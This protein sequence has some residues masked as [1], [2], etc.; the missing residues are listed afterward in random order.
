MSEM[1]VISMNIA[2][3]VTT[4]HRHLSYARPISRSQKIKGTKNEV[5]GD[6]FWR[7]K[8]C[9]QEPKVEDSMP[10]LPELGSRTRG[11]EEPGSHFAVPII[12]RR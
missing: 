5:N 4:C 9:V 12:S 6:S 11:C 7:K 2:S 1:E 3:L 10:Q 8:V